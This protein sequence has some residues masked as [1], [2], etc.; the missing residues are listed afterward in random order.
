M[1]CKENL[2]REIIILLLK[3]C[4][5]VCVIPHQLNWNVIMSSSLLNQAV[6]HI[7]AWS[8]RS[9]LSGRINNDEGEEEETDGETER[10]LF[11]TELICFQTGLELR[12]SIIRKTHTRKHVGRW[13]IHQLLW[14]IDE[15]YGLWRKRRQ[16]EMKGWREEGREGK[17][18]VSRSLKSLEK[19][20]NWQWWSV[21]KYIYSSTVQIRGTCTFFESLSTSTALHFRRK[22]CTLYSPTII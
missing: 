13:N 8:N 5:C 4:V 20:W 2:L 10:L 9:L 3:L 17:R 1:T 11:F 19:T 22:Y 15:G 14:I 12:L 16:E 21:T 7:K 18:C 6:D